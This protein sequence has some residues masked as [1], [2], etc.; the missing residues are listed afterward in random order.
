M[1]YDLLMHCEDCHVSLHHGVG[2]VI[3]KVFVVFDSAVFADRVLVHCGILIM[4]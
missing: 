2:L 3:L 1:A 4:K